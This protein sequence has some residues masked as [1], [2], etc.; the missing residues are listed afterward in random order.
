MPVMMFNSQYI[1]LDNK[2]ALRLSRIKYRAGC[3][4]YLMFVR[5]VNSL[6]MDLGRN[7]EINAV[8]ITSEL[9]SKKFD[10][11]YLLNE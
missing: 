10:N 8:N 6:K 5:K 11:C 9:L 3:F 7:D 1:C 2:T 4:I